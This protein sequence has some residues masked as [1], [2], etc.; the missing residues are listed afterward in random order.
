MRT[1]GLG[2]AHPSAVVSGASVTQRERKERVPHCLLLPPLSHGA[3][4]SRDGRHQAQVIIPGVLAASA[5]PRHP[6]AGRR[7]RSRTSAAALC[8]RTPAA[9][10]RQLDGRRLHRPELQRAAGGVQGSRSQ[11]YRQDR[12]APCAPRSNTSS[13]SGRRSSNTSSS[14]RSRSTGSCASSSTRTSRTRSTST[15]STS[16][17]GRTRLARG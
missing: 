14:S 9:R 12:R 13:S 1:F 10:S 15:S 17:A 4:R 8:A 16:E 6:T 11:S 7:L 5:C 3:H 2:A